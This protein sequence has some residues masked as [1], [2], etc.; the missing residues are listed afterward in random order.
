MPITP[1]PTDREDGTTIRAAH[2]NDMATAVNDLQ[3]QITS[4]PPGGYSA[5]E[6]WLQ[7]GN[8]GTV[9]DFL[10]D[11][12]GPQGPEGP[13]GPGEVPGTA[14]ALIADLPELTTSAA[15]GLEL[16]VSGGEMR[17]SILAPLVAGTRIISTATP[18]ATASYAITD[19]QIGD[20]VRFDLNGSFTNNTGSDQDVT[21]RFTLSSGLTLVYVFTAI[22][23]ATN[24][25]AVG[26][27]ITVIGGSFLGSLV[28]GANGPITISGA[29]STGGGS[30]ADFG[31]LT[32][33]I[34]VD[35]TSIG[36]G[37]TVTAELTVELSAPSASLESSVSLIV[38]RG[39]S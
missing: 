19:F 26:G 10:E 31:T 2:M 29:S 13:E 7:E 21:Y 24:R 34:Q 38:T 5:Y 16:T 8:V 3:G 9:A 11:I 39:R 14:A 36:I 32:R 30:G 12:R 4:L 33:G 28:A 27:R 23:T 6:L 17:A 37:S 1:Q 22:P 25:R 35:P 15:D 20:T 18:T